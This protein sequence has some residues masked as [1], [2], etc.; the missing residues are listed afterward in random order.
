MFTQLLNAI[1]DDQ[2]RAVLTFLLMLPIGW[3]MKLL[4]SPQLRL[5]YSLILGVLLQYYIYSWKM[6]HVFIAAIINLLI[7]KLSP[8]TKVGKIALIYNFTHNSLIHLYR[9]LFEYDSWSIE[10]SVIFMMVMCKFSGF[11][12]AYQDYYMHSNNLLT[13]PLTETQKKYMI[14]NNFSIFEFFSYVYF[15]SSSIVGPFIEYKDFLNFIYLKEQYKNIPNTILPAISRLMTGFLFYGIYTGLK[16]Y[17]LPEN[18]MDDKG[19]FTLSQKIFMYLIS[20]VH[21]YKYIGG[22]CLSEAGLIASGISYS[23]S[24]S[25]DKY[26]TV[27]SINVIDLL[28]VYKPSEFFQNWNISVH[29]WLKRYVYVRLLP[30]KGKPDFAQK[31]F[32]SSVT[33][34]VSALWHGFHPT[35]FVTF[36]HFYFFTLLETQIVK[37]FGGKLDEK[38]ENE[39]LGS[40]YVLKIWTLLCR[41]TVLLVLV[42]FHCLIFVS[43]DTKKLF[44]FLNKINYFGT[45][46]VILPNVLLFVYSSVKKGSKRDRYQVD[47]GKKE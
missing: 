32:A 21:E 38:K 10:I 1:P 9:L 2:F 45:V 36:F 37:V 47:G 31:Q 16:E 13:I 42:P 23:G 26:S 40:S 25:K 35:Y 17:A 6:L 14:E 22:F 44:K 15:V 34:L 29:T 18:I 12:Y 11:A 24:E 4:K 7:L 41:M 46:M 5:I 28:L 33:F 20:S 3:F 27:R 19:R 43:L 30:N 8:P 39:N